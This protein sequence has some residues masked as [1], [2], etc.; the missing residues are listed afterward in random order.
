VAA[1][2]YAIVVFARAC[3]AVGLS[4]WTG[5]RAVVWP[6]VWPG[7]F[8]ATLLA[9]TR[10]MI[11]EGLPALLAHLAAGGAGYLLIFV[12]CGLDVEERQW[13]LAALQRVL[14]RDTHRLATSDVVGS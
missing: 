7:V 4:V 1:I 6:A 2:L 5:Y 14:R 13:L 11:P 12:A 10:T 3:H 9:T 8:V